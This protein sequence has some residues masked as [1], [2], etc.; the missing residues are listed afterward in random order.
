[1]CL[2]F[3]SWPKIK[4]VSKSSKN[5]RW[6]NYDDVV[7]ELE[8]T[9]E[10]LLENLSSDKDASSTEGRIGAR[11]ERQKELEAK[12]QEIASVMRLLRI[13]NR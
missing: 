11:S 7:A 9:N 8:A 12:E 2:R 10:T 5:F 4:V 3:S 13:T 1:M 6:R